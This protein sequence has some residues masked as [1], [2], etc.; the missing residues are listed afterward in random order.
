[1]NAMDDDIFGWFYHDSEALQRVQ[2]ADESA[3]DRTI[4][5]TWEILARVDLAQ[6]RLRPDGRAQIGGRGA[7][8]RRVTLAD[9]LGDVRVPVAQRRQGPV[10][11]IVTRG[12]LIRGAEGRGAVECFEGIQIQ[13]R[14]P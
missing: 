5:L 4:D 12:A 13:L 11:G 7:G 8:K 2:A 10:R 9:R 6:A 3:L 14:D 1:M